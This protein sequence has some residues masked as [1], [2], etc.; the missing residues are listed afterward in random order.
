MRCSLGLDALLPVSASVRTDQHSR[1]FAS[2]GLLA[3]AA[4]RR[5]AT[6]KCFVQ[7]NYLRPQMCNAANVLEAT[8]REEAIPKAICKVEA[9]VRRTSKA[10]THP[11]ICRHRGQL[12]SISTPRF[13]PCESTC[14]L[15]SSDR[16]PDP[17]DGHRSPFRLRLCCS[18]RHIWSS[19]SSFLQGSEYQLFSR[20]KYPLIL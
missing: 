18:G 16:V 6:V 10:I 20:I 8:W 12:A 4:S 3:R 17:P 14:C 9:S 15:S 1:T 2:L 13:I 19:R 7:N 11:H 5:I